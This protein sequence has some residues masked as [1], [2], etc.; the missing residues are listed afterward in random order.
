MSESTN[1]NPAPPRTPGMSAG[2]YIVAYDTICAGWECLKDDEGNPELFGTKAEAEAEIAD[3]LRARNE[4]YA[5]EGS[6]EEEESDC[7]VVPAHEY[8]HNRK[9]IWHPKG[10]AS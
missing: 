6:E 1:G 4:A 3:D 8:V 2:K 5:A 9:A 7:F 10:G